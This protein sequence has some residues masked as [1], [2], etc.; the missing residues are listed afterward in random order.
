[1]KKILAVFLLFV[2]L[3]SNFPVS[4]SSS[5]N[6]LS[7]AQN[8][9]KFLDMLEIIDL[10]NQDNSTLITRAKF[11][12]MLTACMNLELDES[13]ESVFEDVTSATEYAS[14]INTAYKFGLVSGSANGLFNPESP[15]S[16]EAVLKMCTIAL[17]YEKVANAYGG[18]PA[19]YTRIA[20]EIGLTDGVN[21]DAD[22]LNNDVYVLLYNFL[23][24]DIAEITSVLGDGSY[25]IK[26]NPG[27]TPLYT[28]FNL[29]KDEGVIKTAG[30]VS[31][32]YNYDETDAS[33]YMNG[34]TYAVDIK[35]C[36][37]YLGIYADI[38][39]DSTNRVRAIYPGYQNE[40]TRINSDEID[41]FSKGVV[42]I[43]DENDRT[44]KLSLSPSYT[45]VKNGRSINP[46]QA[47]FMVENAEY[48]FIDNDGNS[49]FDVVLSYVPEYI[50]VSSVD[51]VEGM[52]YDN[53]GPGKYLNLN[54]EKGVY[55]TLTHID[56][57]GISSPITMEDL[58]KNQVIKYY[59]SLDGAYVAGEV[60]SDTIT[61]TIDEKGD[62]T[63]FIGGKEYEPNSYFTNASKL[64]FGTQYV[65]YLAPDGT[66]TYA[67]ASNSNEM[68][69]GF[70]IDFK[71]RTQGLSQLSYIKILTS[72]NELLETELADEIT[73]DGERGVENDSPKL[74]AKLKNQQ[75]TSITKCQ[76]IRYCLSNEGKVSKID[77]AIKIEDGE[78]TPDKFI[79]TNAGD[80]ILTR[81]IYNKN[82][83]YHGAY[84]VFAPSA[85]IGSETIMFSLP[86]DFETNS[87]L[88]VEYDEDDFA[89]ITTS[90]LQSYYDDGLNVTMYD[91]NRN[92]EPAVVLVY[93]G[94]SG[95]N[96]VVSSTSVPAV[97]KSVSQGINE[98]G[99]ITT[100][101]S[102]FSGTKSQKLV[103]QQEKNSTLS[104]DDLPASGDII[105]YVLDKNGEIANFI[106]DVRYKSA[107]S[108][109]SASLERTPS[110]L[111]GGTKNHNIYTG[112]VYNH[113]ASSLSMYV[114]GGKESGREYLADL[115]GFSVVS[116]CSVVVYDSATKSAKAGTLDMLADALCVGKDNASLIAVKTYTH[117]ASN[118]FIYK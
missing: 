107:T 68:Q 57:E 67:I 56:P 70:L 54:T 105:R 15:I 26:R 103:V 58:S 55:Y 24:S 85:V 49:S 12:A 33:I 39:Y 109:R 75:N 50:M 18:Y 53:N 62:D 74:T 108:S 88:P 4:A 87:D 40:L 35:G 69:Y 20:K 52:I 25:T 19:G 104:K 101:I 79:E 8:E 95:K 80:D 9:A 32:L 110:A 84:R 118:I 42:T 93:N 43:I 71:F 14:S 65:F 16:F 115:A 102:L 83:F 96:A 94:M 34:K 27:N 6:Q 13:N 60:G 38:Y 66:L 82:M 48:V 106:I 117:Q 5:E 76:L 51:V 2:L 22:F 116:N 91:I 100:M 31:M 97:V 114:T 29:Q 7:T 73:L 72:G 36:E 1:M 21:C 59:R 92:L 3:V 64:T 28:Y 44:K 30:H 47:D 98:D 46:S 45:F 78:F 86:S 90:H 112:K 89:V 113:S 77:T 81:H 17:G 10:E 99:E 37:E 41:S 23:V 61:G 63:L 111:N 11:C